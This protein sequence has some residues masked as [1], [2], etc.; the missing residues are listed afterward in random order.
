MNYSTRDG[1]GVC[2]TRYFITHAMTYS[3]TM[4]DARWL[5]RC[6]F[7]R[8]NSL[9]LSLSRAGAAALHTPCALSRGRPRRARGATGC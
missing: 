6:L 1:H 8:G 9:R 2:S 3:M 5:T 7:S 4:L